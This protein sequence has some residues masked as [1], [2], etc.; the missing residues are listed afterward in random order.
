M[1][2]DLDR[3]AIRFIKSSNRTVQGNCKNRKRT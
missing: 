3:F 1:F 2:K